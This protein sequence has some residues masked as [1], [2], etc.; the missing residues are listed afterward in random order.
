MQWVRTVSSRPKINDTSVCAIIFLDRS[1]NGQGVAASSVLHPTIYQS[2]T[3]A[4][5]QGACVT[6]QSSHP[7]SVFVPLYLTDLLQFV[8]MLA[9]KNNLI[10]DAYWRFSIVCDQTNEVE[11][12]L[13]IDYAQMQS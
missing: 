12:C 1:G 6:I 13:K 2:V 11:L 7:L 4:R 10:T 8:P 9:V 3:V 5:F